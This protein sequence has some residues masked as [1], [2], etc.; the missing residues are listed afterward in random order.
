[1]FHFRFDGKVAAHESSDVDCGNPA[2]AKSFQHQS[3]LSQTYPIR[4]YCLQYRETDLAFIQRLLAEEGISY[5][6]THGPDPKTSLKSSDDANASRNS[7]GN[8]AA[9]ESS[10][11]QGTDTPLHTLILFDANHHLPEN[12]QS[13][14]RFH[15]TDGIEADDAIDQ[16]TGSRQIHSSQTQLASYDYK[17][18]ATHVGN[19]DTRT[20]RVLP[21]NGF[22]LSSGRT[23]QSDPGA[24]LTTSLE[25]Y[26]PQTGY[27]GADPDEMARYTKLRQQAKDLTNKTFQ[28][29]GTVRSLHPGT[30]FELQDH[31]IHDQDNPEDRQFLVTGINF[32]AEN[33]LTPEAKQSLGGLLNASS[34]ASNSIRDEEDQAAAVAL[35]L[36][37]PGWENRTEILKL[38]E[39]TGEETL[40]ARCSDIHDLLNLSSRA[41]RVEA[42]RQVSISI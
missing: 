5:R 35:Q 7:T 18:V 8:S 26:D 9:N 4:S 12:G 10:D 11:G 36:L 25:D 22:A 27:Y 6:F 34:P 37:H 20:P 30:W 16:W 2:I 28:G 23:Q 15:R 38:L 32:E 3:E 1:M 41:W 13:L 31:P 29:Q 33:N 39:E 24:D 19:E 14:A 21:Q 42:N 17:A 40:A